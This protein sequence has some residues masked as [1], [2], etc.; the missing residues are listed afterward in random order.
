MTYREDRNWSNKYI[1]EISEII[2]LNARFLMTINVSSDDKDMG[3]ATDLVL[4]IG[5]GDIAIRLLREKKYNTFTIRSFRS[6]GTKTELAK[7][8]SGYAKWY[9]FGWCKDE[10][11]D[12]WLIIDLDK[13][14]ESG[15]LD[16]YTTIM[17]KDKTT[18]FIA[19]PLEDLAFSECIVASKTLSSVIRPQVGNAESG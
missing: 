1:P 11:L 9:F 13:L 18:G 19:I 2:G 7:I 5:G 16:G 4:S 10:V 8:K 17:N 15:L 3:E 14:R 12:D 6:S